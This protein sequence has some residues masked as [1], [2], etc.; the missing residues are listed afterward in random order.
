MKKT[1]GIFAHVDA[2]KTT[3]SEQLL[4]HTKSI[5]T[6]GRVDHK[7]AFL[8]SHKI[9]KERGITVFSDIGVFNYKDCEY[10]LI[11]TPGHI[12]FSPEMERTISI[13]DYAI[14]LIS[15][16]E[17][18]QGHTETVWQLLRKHNIPTF[19]FINKMDR[20]GADLDR[21]I[22]EVKNTLTDD[23]CLISDRDLNNLNEETI[24]FIAERDEELFEFYLENGYDSKLWIEKLKQLVK[25][26]KI[27]IG[28]KGSALLDQG[29]EEFLE[30]FHNLSYTDYIEK[31]FENNTF[32][33]KENDDYIKY[34]DSSINCGNN[35]SNKR[36]KGRVFKVRYDEKGNRVTFLKVLSGE[37]KV[38]DEVI[39]NIDGEEKREK[40]N[41]IRRYSG[42]KF[43][44]RDIIYPGEVLGLVG[45]TSLCPGMAVGIEE[46]L[47]YDMVPTLRAKV[48]VD[49][50][51]NSRDVLKYFR[52]LESEENSLNV[53]WSEEFQ[54]I[55]IS[56]MGKIQLEVLKE[57]LIDRFSL[58]VEF[59]TPEILYKET[60]KGETEGFGHF[61]PL[62]HYAEVQLK[63]EEGPRGSGITY[64]NKC[65][66]D[67]LTTGNQNLIRTH[68]FEREHR[69]ILTGSTVTDIKVTLLTGRAHNKH[70]E[71]GDF[72]EA[73]KRA[74]RQGLETIENMLLEP[75]YKFKID[76]DM[77]LMGRVISDIQKMSGEFE[78]P[79]S[80]GNRV[81]ITGR[82]PVATF[83][84]YS[85]EFQAF[86]H[87]KGSLNLIFHGYDI[88]HNTEEIIETK[89]YN[90]N[91]DPEYTSSSIFCAKGV[92]YSV[93]WDEVKSYMH[94]LK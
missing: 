52:I 93:P 45:I 25:E 69:G 79:R 33:S 68:I 4:Y 94:C 11:D 48:E 1:I 57:I 2:G 61:E 89:G 8:D 59:G 91:A 83:M 28:T 42:N 54:E 62:R 64:E 22:E 29:V 13:L 23:I 34:K 50:K 86:T 53:V 66:S 37:L 3:F 24:E 77:N 71:G 30:I 73:T 49:E 84:N 74:L 82:G 43:E 47:T 7:E 70:T 65:H 44:V 46:K 92:G 16:V 10:Y 17:G 40:I 31:V 6:R 88:C 32:V 81:V 58:K 60:I 15:A 35:S 76:V 51:L 85:L 36:L 9:E 56:I 27:F 87:G 78:E 38:K 39:Y 12:D 5:R 63:L 41:E 72:R 80:Y 18:V 20:E 55:H 67:F 90:K 26:N 75:Y 14:V 19:I 21:V